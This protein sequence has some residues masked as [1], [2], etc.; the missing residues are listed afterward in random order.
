MRRSAATSAAAFLLASTVLYLAVTFGSTV[1]GGADQYSYVTQAGL[2]RTGTLQIH[3]DIVRDSPWPGAPETWTPL[4]FR[5]IPGDPTAI[6]SVYPPGLPLLMA[7]FQAVVG[8]CGAFLVVPCF[9]ALTIWL[10]YQLGRQLFDAPH[11]GL[12]AAALVAASPVFLYQIMNAMS[13][14]PVTAAWTL[15]LLLVVSQRPLLSGLVVGAAIT[16]RP[17]LA[18]LAGV[19]AV[20]LILTNR[21]SVFAFAAGVAPGL[22]AVLLV[23]WR[24]YGSPLT[25][26]YGELGQYYAWAFAPANLRRYPVWIV[27][28]QTPL[29]LLAVCLFVAP[30]L[31]PAPRVAHLR[32]LLGGIVG[33]VF[34][35]YLFYTPFDAWWFLRFLLPMWPVIMLLTAV[36]LEMLARRWTGRWSAA[37]VWAI[38]AA[39]GWRGVRLA[40]DRSAFDLGWGDRRY[41]NVARFVAEHTEPD[42]VI[43]SMQ[44]SGSIRH[45]AG[46]L[47]LRFDLLDRAALDRAIAFL[48]SARRRPY[49][50]LDGDEVPIFRARFSG[51]SR[52]AALDWTPMATLAA[53]AIFVFDPLDVGRTDTPL[54]IST[55][56][57]RAGWRCTE[58]PIWPPLL[59]LK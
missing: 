24:M 55:L 33:G 44:H 41:V 20:W 34:L 39:V 17:N 59:R 40:S 43:L 42:A 18:P 7:L 27:D 29:V 32:T 8:Y 19:F 52:L 53:P 49:I 48:Q 36:A 50:V 35:S 31:L 25:S 45:Y 57:S 51:R 47:T 4:G 54:A 5:T 13:D 37:V 22:C 14:V 1:A 3:Q 11:A 9:A 26:G 16:I 21:R 12:V 6:A 2:W 15:A 23:N 30:H 56:N 10:T 46:R 38:V 58:P 28:T